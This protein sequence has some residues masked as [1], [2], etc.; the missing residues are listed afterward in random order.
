MNCKDA[1]DAKRYQAFVDEDWLVA[2]DSLLSCLRHR[3][4]SVMQK[5]CEYEE[6]CR[7]GDMARKYY[8][9]FKFWKRLGEQEKPDS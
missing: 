1:K 7:L 6:I 3:H 5:I 4:G 9:D 8:N 2:V